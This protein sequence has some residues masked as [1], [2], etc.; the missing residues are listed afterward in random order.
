MSDYVFFGEAFRW[1]PTEIDRL[2]WLFRKEMKDL[3]IDA[4]K[5]QIDELKSGAR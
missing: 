4:K 5:K 2:G 3:Y 1:S